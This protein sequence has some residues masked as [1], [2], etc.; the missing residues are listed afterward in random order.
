MLLWTLHL[1]TS[2]MRTTFISYSIH[3]IIFKQTAQLFIYRCY[4]DTDQY[5]LWNMNMNHRKKMQ[6]L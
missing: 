4:Y 3:F 1:F 2:L 6:T 5:D